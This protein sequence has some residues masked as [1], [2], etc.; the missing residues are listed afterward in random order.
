M[1]AIKALRAGIRFQ[2]LPCVIIIRGA[3]TFLVLLKEVVSSTPVGFEIM[4]ITRKEA[5]NKR[6]IK[7]PSST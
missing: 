7:T 4:L 6:R 5:I 1:D 2:E 3:E